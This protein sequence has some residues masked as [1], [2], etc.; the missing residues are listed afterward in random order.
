M[1]I[2]VADITIAG[3]G[4]AG[5]A[6][7]AAL[8]GRGASVVLVDPSEDLTRAAWPNRYGGWLDELQALGLPIRASWAA[9]YVDLGSGP[10]SL[11]PT[12]AWI[13]R[14]SAR[15]HL[16]DR[17]DGRF[18][19]GRVTAAHPDTTGLDLHL[20]DGRTLR[21]RRL[22][23]ATGRG[24]LVERPHAPRAFQ[25]ALGWLLRTPHP[26]TDGR[27]AFMDFSDAHL[28]AA[29]RSAGPATFLYALPLDDEHVFVEETSLAA[30]PALSLDLLQRRLELRLAALG[31]RTDTILE[32]ERCLIPMDTP[33][34]HRGP[35]LAVGA[36]AGWVHPA[37]GYQVVRAFRQAPSIAQ[38]LV[39][40]LS[41]PL[42]PAMQR[43][44]RAVWPTSHQRTRA[45]HDM[46]LS[47]LLGLDAARTRSFFD[48]FFDI[49]ESSW[50]A[51]LDATSPPTAVAR[52]MTQVLAALPRPMQGTVLSHATGQGRT[53]LLRALTLRPLGGAP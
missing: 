44:W 20:A 33:A 8:S 52:A 3:A 46:G 34:P 10:R 9:P 51:Y 40:D 22:V 17:F 37:T 43:A 49:P 16:V 38:A 19:S 15:R 11:A 1:S 29:E 25:T 21:T 36:A 50:R 13:D 2:P 24:A 14:A 41:S 26:F 5:L 7:A 53:A 4:P 47:L 48:R 23:D 28:P 6:L 39:Q 27:A 12:Y 30:A 42:E 31:L 32:T 35:V 45:L 18:V